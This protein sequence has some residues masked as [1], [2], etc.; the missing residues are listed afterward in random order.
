MYENFSCKTP[1]N[2]EKDVFELE[3]AELELIKRGL[4]KEKSTSAMLIPA[5]AVPM[6]GNAPI[7]KNIRPCP[8]RCPN[9]YNCHNKY[10]KNFRA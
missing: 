7:D 3:M 5:H 1:V 8:P 4:M 2:I 10:C 9:G 6:P